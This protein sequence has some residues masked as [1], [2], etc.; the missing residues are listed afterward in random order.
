MR[1]TVG[2]IQYKAAQGEGEPEN[3]PFVRFQHGLGAN[4]ASRASA[5]LWD[6]AN[7]WVYVRTEI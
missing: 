5:R 3:I 6:I 1:E 7:H 2:M 4:E